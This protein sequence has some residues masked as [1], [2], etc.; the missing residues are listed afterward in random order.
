MSKRSS[1]IKHQR[2]KARA[3]F[4]DREAAVSEKFYG[5]QNTDTQ[6]R[7]VA[8]LEKRSTVQGHVIAGEAC[9]EMAYAAV[10]DGKK[11]DLM[12]R[13]HANW[14]RAVE[15]HGMMSEHIDHVTGRALTHLACWP[16]YN[17]HVT[18]G[19][20]APPEQAAKAYG[21][22]L[23]VTLEHVK[24]LKHFKELDRVRDIKDLSGN[25]AELNVLLLLQRFGITLGDAS[26]LALPSL[27]SANRGGSA[28]AYFVDRWDI[29]V[30]TQHDKTEPPTMDYKV[31]VK[32]HPKQVQNEHV[33]DESI[34]MVY[35][36][37]DLGLGSAGRIM[38]LN[39][40]PSECLRETEQASQAT[41][42]LDQRTDKLLEILG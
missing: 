36:R 31:Q 33:Y 26:W 25:L 13:A 2:K 35:A 17:W 42:R 16:L 21:D 40:I 7:Y 39:V 19:Q 14:R 32:S 30:F 20:I 15:N 11:V 4:E 3:V 5:T 23:C 29:S 34:T 37:T 28:G 41:V 10:D 18:L 9:L 6:M 22:L 27:T 12:D 38:P 1:G 24:A 8:Q